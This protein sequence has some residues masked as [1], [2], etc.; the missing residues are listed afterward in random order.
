[1]EIKIKLL[2]NI[3]KRNK[4]KKLRLVHLQARRLQIEGLSE[5]LRPLLT[6]NDHY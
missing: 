6:I 5:T 1:M 2:S 4:E 3:S